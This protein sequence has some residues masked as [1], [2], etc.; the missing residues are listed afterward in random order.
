MKTQSLRLR[1]AA[2]LAGVA[3]LAFSGWAGADPPSRVAR[4]AYTSGA[5]SMSPAG[6]NEWVQ[7]TVNRPLTTGDRLWVDDGARAEL[8]TGG[9]LVRM[10]AGTS[11]SVLNLDD[12]IT[13][14]QLTQG[15]L[16]V[17]VRRIA[18]NQI[19]EVDTPNLAFTLREPG[20]YRIEV[21]SEDDATTIFMRRGQGEAYGDEAAYVI[22]S[23]QAYRFTGTDLREY[24]YVDAPRPDDFDRWSNSRDRRYDESRSAGYVS[25][26]VV[27]YQDLD[28]YGS[29][30]ADATYG[31]VWYPDRVAT[32]WAPYRD[33]HWAW[34]DP[35]GWTWVDDAPWGFAVSH[36]GRWAHVGGTWGW[37]PGPVRSRAYYAPALVV[38]VGGGDF[39]LTISSGLVGAVAWFPLGPREVYR[40][41]YRVS[42][43]YFENINRSNT[44]V[45]NTV[46]N[47]YYNNSN[48]TNVVYIN[49]SVEGAVV[50]VPTTAFVQSQPVSREAL[51]VSRETIGSAPLALVAPLAPTEKS[52]RGA[53]AQGGKPPPRALERRVVARTAPPP[54]P[55]GFVA[56]QQRLS[57]EPGR[58]L[59]ES[60]RKELRSAATAPA[61]AVKVITRKQDG[62]PRARPPQAAA[63]AKAADDTGGRSEQPDR[64]ARRDE[65]AAPPAQP[66][67]RSMQPRIAPPQATTPA[68]PAAQSREPRGRADRRGDDEQRGQ[69]AAPR[70]ATPQRPAEP[71]PAPPRATP[72]APATPATP[73]TRT[74]PAVP[75]V[76]ATPAEPAAQSPEPRGKSEQRD[77]REQRRERQQREQA[78]TPPPAPARGVAPPETAPPRP[79][80]E[81]PAAQSR[82]PRDR[83]EQRGNGGQRERERAVAPPPPPPAQQPAQR[84]R[85]E[86]APAAEPRGQEPRPAAGRARDKN[87]DSEEQKQEEE[88]RRRDERR[89]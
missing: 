87:K 32:G 37:V 76:P 83:S 44:I 84:A 88:Q 59:D 2:F 43:D 80:P 42:R 36:Y 60:V 33:G 68:E 65:P 19:F 18:P 58:P 66:P 30:R 69:T 27:G 75:A 4:L 16:N 67:Q 71:E 10:H 53:A 39:Q 35:W 45:N 74:T 11:V 64:G 13:Q 40:P 22:D 51:R 12:R 78:V 57:A 62:M 47:N 54:A 73:A 72:A 63:R 17:R 56:Q 82:E 85:P 23:R 38:F 15:A 61:P 77:E 14:L 21:D 49:R 52:V 34:I 1:I 6:D 31:N 9:A 8:E 26:D 50:A 41:A 20:A 79:A 48:V 5:V 89:N 81:I 86:P 70:P 3:M 28:D 46:I 55:V 25:Q 24:E 29:W 7:A